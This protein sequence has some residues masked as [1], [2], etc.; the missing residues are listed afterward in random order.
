MAS[1][2]VTAD[3]D[4]L[5]EVGASAFSALADTMQTLLNAK[6]QRCKGTGILKRFAPVFEPHLS[7][8]ENE[9]SSFV[10]NFQCPFAASLRRD[11]A[12]NLK[13]DR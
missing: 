2:C 12:L 6:A 13:L 3:P 4:E 5:R 9:S 10:E 11:F 7:M 1:I 8:S